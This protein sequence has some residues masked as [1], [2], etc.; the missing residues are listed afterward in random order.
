MLEAATAFMPWHGNSQSEW[1]CAMKFVTIG[2]LALAAVGPI[3][4]LLLGIELK[5]AG[6]MFLAMLVAAAVAFV[7]SNLKAT[8]NLELDRRLPR[9]LLT[10]DRR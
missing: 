4:A 2:F 1:I 3:A 6:L 8:L 10:S 5:I 9:A 7:I